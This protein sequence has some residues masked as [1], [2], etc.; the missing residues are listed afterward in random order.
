M[1]NNTTN[2]ASSNNNENLLSGESLK[3]LVKFLQRT[4][5]NPSEIDEFLNVLKALQQ[6][7]L[8]LNK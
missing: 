1:E 3:S 2:S 8:L 4:T 7:S 6:F 5:L